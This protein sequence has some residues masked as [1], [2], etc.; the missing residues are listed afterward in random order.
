MENATV[1]IKNM[2]G[3]IAQQFSY[4]GVQQEFD[5]RSLPVG[6]YTIE[7]LTPKNTEVHKIIKK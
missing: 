5:I 2:Q 1:Y 7:L 3:Q 6:Q 4:N